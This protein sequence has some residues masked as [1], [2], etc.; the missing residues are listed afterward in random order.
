MGCIAIMPW[1]LQLPRAKER[2]SSPKRHCERSVL[3]ETDVLVLCKMHTT[4]LAR[5]CEEVNNNTLKL[6]SGYYEFIGIIKN[7]SH[8]ENMSQKY[9]TVGT[10]F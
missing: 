1:T 8:L 5:L 9:C 6:V 2:N 10:L 4:F 3:K 7:V